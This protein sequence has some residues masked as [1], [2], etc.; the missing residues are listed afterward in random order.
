MSRHAVQPLEPRPVQTRTAMR[1][2]VTGSSCARAPR[3]RNEEGHRARRVVE[4]EFH[5]IPEKHPASEQPRDGAEHDEV[6]TM[7]SAI[8]I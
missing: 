1:A 2:T 3:G 8:S 5:G 6:R 4:H 7:S